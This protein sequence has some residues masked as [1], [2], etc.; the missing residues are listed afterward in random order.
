MSESETPWYERSPVLAGTVVAAAVVLGQPFITDQWPHQVAEFLRQPWVRFAVTVLG[1]GAA[2]MVGYV[3]GRRQRLPPA[4]APHFVIQGATPDVR[5]TPAHAPPTDTA[6]HIETGRP[7]DRGRVGAVTTPVEF[8][9]AWQS[10]TP[11]ERD[12]LMLLWMCEE[13]FITNDEIEDW[14]F[15]HKW[16]RGRWNG[17][18][19]AL[20]VQRKLIAK[21]QRRQSSMDGVLSGSISGWELTPEGKAVVN[22]GTRDLLP[23]G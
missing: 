2:V 8:V 4:P 18:E 7:P 20:H 22:V 6:Q 12:V 10:M 15:E 21:T 13:T 9:F 19:Y 3:L 23:P 1:G 5:A 17:V 11:D 14:I 16:T